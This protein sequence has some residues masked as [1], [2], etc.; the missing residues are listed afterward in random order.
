MK[1]YGHAIGALP[2]GYFIIESKEELA[3]CA[4]DL[5][6][7]IDRTG[8]RLVLLGR[9]RIALLV[10]KG[11]V[12]VDRGHDPFEHPSSS[13]TM[14]GSPHHRIKEMEAIIPELLID[15]HE[16]LISVAL[17]RRHWT[18]GQKAVLANEYRKVLS[19]KQKSKRAKIAVT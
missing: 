6:N 17:N 19:E 5:Q 12:L 9:L 8:E 14:A 18:E 7:R 16:F 2:V 1:K 11:G 3:E 13:I 4:L 10:R 15:E